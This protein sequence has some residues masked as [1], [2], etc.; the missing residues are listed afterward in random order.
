MKKRENN[1]QYY[2]NQREIAET[3]ELSKNPK[4]IEIL[5]SN[6]KSPPDFVVYSSIIEA[7]NENTFVEDIF[8][9]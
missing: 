5:I 4:S 3:L 1:S 2:T 8:V 7:K 6:I 9:E